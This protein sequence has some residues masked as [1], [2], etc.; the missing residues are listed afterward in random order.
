MIVSWETPESSK[1]K[2]VEEGHGVAEGVVEGGRTAE[3][4]K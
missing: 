3:G 2:W 1:L 4:D